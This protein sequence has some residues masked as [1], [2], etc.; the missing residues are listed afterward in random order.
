M[1]FRTFRRRLEAE[2]SQLSYIPSLIAAGICITLAIVVSVTGKSGYYKLL[3][4]LPRGT[5]PLLFRAFLEGVFYA[6]LGFSLGAFLFSKR[7]CGCLFYWQTAFLFVCAIFFSYARTIAVYQAGTPFF[8]LLYAVLTVLCLCLLFFTLKEN[9][10]LFACF[11]FF[12]FL[13]SFYVLYHTLTIF[14]LNA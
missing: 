10:F 5:P 9:C 2:A 4:D 1:C 3:Y 12:C 6:V 13:L 7:I 11:V 14:L 8:G